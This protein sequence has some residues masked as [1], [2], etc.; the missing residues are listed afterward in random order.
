MD[1]RLA[2]I[3]SCGGITKNAYDKNSFRKKLLIYEHIHY[4]RDYLHNPSSPG[5]CLFQDCGQV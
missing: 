5:T 3:E 1:T 2:Q 4:L